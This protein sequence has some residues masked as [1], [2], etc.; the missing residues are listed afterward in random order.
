MIRLTLV[1]FS[2]ITLFSSLAFSQTNK[3]IR[4]L[5]KNHTELQKQIANTESMLKTTKKD[6]GSLLHTISSISGQIEKR[7]SYINKIE[8]DVIEIDKE[9]SSITNQMTSLEAELKEKKDRYAE[10]IRRTQKINTAENNLMF[11]LSAKD[12]EQTY[13]RIRYVKEYADY[14]KRLA[15]DIKQKQQLLGGKKTEFEEVKSEK[16]KLKQLREQERRNLEKSE[17][18]K[19]KIVE[20]LQK[21]QKQLQQDIRNKRAE[22]DR[23]NKQIDKL[24]AEEIEKAKKKAAEE[25]KRKRAERR[26]KQSTSKGNKA[27]N[28]EEESNKAEQVKAASEVISTTED[29]ELSGSF[30]SNKGRLPMPISGSYIV[31]NRFGKYNVGGMRNVVLDNKGIDIQGQPGAK[32]LSVF[33]GR[34][35]AVFSLNGLY[36]VLVRHGSYI[37]VYCNLSSVSVKNGDNVSARQQLGTVYTDNANNNRTELHFQLRKETVKLNPEQWLRK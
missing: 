29:I 31:T 14:Q 27:E 5:K 26:R 3:K 8:A 32:A 30:V 23:L 36:N 9:L 20:G 25:E 12:L 13:R 24:I 6:V 11:I 7:K 22:A 10:A 1:F 18:N 33:R 17:K 2:C 21:K 37:S 4:D 19:R 16:E 34:V 35:A 15:Q 28:K